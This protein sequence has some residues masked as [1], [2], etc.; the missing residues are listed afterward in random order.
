MKTKRFLFLLPLIALVSC[1]TL[2]QQI[3]REA[4]LEKAEA[5]EAEEF[6]P[7]EATFE[8]R[9][10]SNN[11]YGKDD[12]KESSQG[13]ALV[14]LNYLGEDE[15]APEMHYKSDSK[16][17]ADG[18]NTRETIDFYLVKS[19]DDEWASYVKYYNSVSMDEAEIKAYEGSFTEV[20]ASVATYISSITTMGSMMKMYLKPVNLIKSMSSDD[21]E[22]QEEAGQKA[23][24]Y[25]SGDKNL[26]IKY[27][28][29]RPSSDEESEDDHE[30]TL[31]SS[32]TI[33]YKNNRLVKVESSSK[34]SYGNKSSSKM[35]F[36]YKNSIKIS[37]PK[38]WD[39]Y[40]E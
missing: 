22:S 38:G 9:I 2:G 14:A 7:T 25:S 37:L 40:L 26:A 27:N 28:Y 3:S 24:F 21:E 36:T 39:G 19:G 29:N 11:N 13:S 16:R 33:E 32:Y 30:N 8:A 34:S 17:S 15:A 10:S 5:I 1:S 20:S 23:S 35:T 6:E 18:D 12:T 4:A 31:S